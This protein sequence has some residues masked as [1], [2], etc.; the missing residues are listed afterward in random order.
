MSRIIPACSECENCGSAKDQN[1]FCSDHPNAIV[2]S[3]VRYNRIERIENTIRFGWREL[4]KTEAPHLV[5]TALRVDRDDAK[6]VGLRGAKAFG[7]ALL[8]GHLAAVRQ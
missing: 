4:A 6:K 8:R 1:W 2:E 3:I 5:T 7:E